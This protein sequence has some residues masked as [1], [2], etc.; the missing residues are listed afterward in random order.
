MPTNY[1][2]TTDLLTGG[3]PLSG[4]VNPQKYVDDAA[5]EIDSKIGHIYQ[6]PI[7]V[8][9]SGPVSRPARLLIKRINNHLATARIIMAVTASSQTLE[10][11]AYAERL[12]REA[13]EALDAIASGDVILDGAVRVEGSEGVATGPQIHN[14]DPESYV[15]AFYNRISNPRYVYYGFGSGEGLVR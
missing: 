1:S 11:N 5:D 7:D 3:V 10:T 12:L 15:E 8:S 13:T 2:A 9:E 4:P 6:T 14:L